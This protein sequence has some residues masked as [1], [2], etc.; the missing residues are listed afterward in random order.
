MIKKNSYNVASSTA[1]SLE[2]EREGSGAKATEGYT[3]GPYP[4]SGSEEPRITLYHIATLAESPE[5][6]WQESWA[7]R[8]IKR[9]NGAAAYACC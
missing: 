6:N 9:G 7:S 5:G 8:K 3:T 1:S 2:W 4:P